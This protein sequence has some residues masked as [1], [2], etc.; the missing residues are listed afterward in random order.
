LNVQDTVIHTIG[1]HPDIANTLLG[2]FGKDDPSFLF[3]NNMLTSRFPFA[4]FVF[5]NGFGMVQPEGHFVFDHNSNS[6]MK[7]EGSVSQKQIEL[8]KAYIQKLYWDF[9]SR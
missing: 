6:I 2:Q 7:Q 3:S 5:N 9:N 1:G 8:G 4:M